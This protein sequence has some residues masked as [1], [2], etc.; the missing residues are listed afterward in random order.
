L[1]V[2]DDIVGCLISDSLQYK[3]LEGFYRI[4]STM[5]QNIQRIIV[6]LRYRPSD[7]AIPFLLTNTRSF[8]SID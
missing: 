8:R 3:C 5:L 4:L 1:T 7:V 6:L 2:R